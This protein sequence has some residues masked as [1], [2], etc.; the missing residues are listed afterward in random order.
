MILNSGL[1]RFKGKSPIY[2]EAAIMMKCTA[3]AAVLPGV[4]GLISWNGENLC[5]LIHPR[6]EGLILLRKNIVFQLSNNQ[7]MDRFL[8]GKNWIT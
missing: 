7:N 2:S 1:K 6:L 4:R 5:F 8:K 3:T